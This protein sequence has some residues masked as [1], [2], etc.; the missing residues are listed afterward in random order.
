MPSSVFDRIRG[1][2]EL[3]FQLGLGGPQWSNNSGILQARNAAN[4]SFA[5]VRG[6]MPV[7][8]NDL[9]TKAYADQLAARYVVTDQF[10]GNNSLPANTST[11]HFIVVTTTGANASIG[12]LLW[13]NGSSSGTASVIGAAAGAM[14]VTTQ[15]LAG[16]TVTFLADSL[17][18]WD[19]SSGAWVN[20]GGSAAS[21]AI[22][23]IR[24]AIN[25]AA[26]QASTQL[27]PASAIVLEAYVDVQVAYSALS[28]ISV[29]QTGT[30]NLL[31]DGVSTPIEVLSTATAIYGKR[32]NQDW[33]GTARAV[34]VTIAGAPSVGSGYAIVKYTQP[35]V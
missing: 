11:E 17:Y 18:V 4:S 33:G 29:G 34:L 9:V 31:L 20:A 1:T 12:Q 3:L 35:N 5:I 19:A 26:S 24:F 23:T 13:D 32:M 30:T 21:G 22:R 15:A 7:G 8:D 28:T 16:G 14:I 10:D 27:I 2:S 25:N 6:A